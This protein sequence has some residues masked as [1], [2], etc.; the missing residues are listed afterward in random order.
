MTCGCW[1]RSGG[2][3]G[4]CQCSISAGPGVE[5]T[6]GGATWT[7]GVKKDPIGDNA[8]EIGP[9]GLKVTPTPG[10]PGP[11][12]KDGAAGPPG[13][14][15]KD[16][17]VPGPPGPAGKD[18][19]FTAANVGDGLA[20]RDGKAVANA[21]PCAPV[22]KH[23]TVF[24]EANRKDN[25]T[26]VRAGLSNWDQ[27]PNP[28]GFTI[29]VQVDNGPWMNVPEQAGTA[30]LASWPT[31]CQRTVRIRARIVD[32]PNTDVRGQ[33][34]VDDQC[35]ANPVNLP[36]MILCTPN[37]LKIGPEGLYVDPDQLPLGPPGPRGPAGP[38]GL[39]GPRG[40][41]GPQ[42]KPGNL[43]D[44]YKG[45]W[46]DTATYNIGDVVTST[47]GL[48]LARCDNVKSL[49]SASDPCWDRLLKNCCPS[50]CIPEISAL[51]ATVNGSAIDL[52]WHLNDISG[53]SGYDIYRRE[54]SPGVF[55]KIGSAPV[56][57]D[58][59]FKDVGPLTPDTLYTYRVVAIGTGPC[60]G[61][62]E[63]SNL[64]TARALA[65]LAK[66]DAKATVTGANAFNIEWQPMRD[67]DYYEITVT[68]P[69]GAVVFHEK[70]GPSEADV[71]PRPLLPTTQYKATLIAGRNN[72]ATSPP[73]EFTLTTLKVLDPPTN[74]QFWYHKPTFGAI[75]IQWDYDAAN[76]ERLY[77]F[78]VREIL[79]DGSAGT[80]HNY[81]PDERGTDM[82]NYDVSHPIARLLVEAFRLS[83]A[84]DDPEV[85]ERSASASIEV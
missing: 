29:E 18:G 45:S 85:S 4:D 50:D 15:G 19:T 46:D 22:A 12:G 58:A 42:G 71:Y 20:F 56:S 1:G 84:P 25:G 77:G 83:P 62:R 26:A 27:F 35:Q 59:T 11:P 67:V 60:E 73:A 64:V 32:Y 5:V 40:D 74:L 24:F 6:G 38:M 66:P 36:D 7:V 8:L 34:A 37:A 75:G 81:P 47:T 61:Q 31:P 68:D 70:L 30:E 14:D 63:V 33:L 3:G 39:P 2:S 48:Y 80:V 44:A 54:S 21:A 17:T 76:N 52:A 78:H 79:K 49:P 23:V 13:K 16:S 57:T 41:T 51:T 10:P 82:I 69:G 9:R 53:V 43:A 28:R 65:P 72:G 55:V